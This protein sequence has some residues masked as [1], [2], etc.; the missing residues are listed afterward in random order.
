[1]EKRQLRIEVL[2][3]S[4]VIQSDESAEHLNR[5]A[6]YVK[7]KIEE[8]KERYKFA[9]PLTVSLLATL[10]IADELFKARDGRAP[11]PEPSFPAQ[12]IEGVALRILNSM[13]EALL[14]HVPYPKDPSET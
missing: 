2:G 12:E 5:L 8:V 6:A 10:N 11:V 7:T 13:D 9:D 1:M 3:T 14:E 4:F